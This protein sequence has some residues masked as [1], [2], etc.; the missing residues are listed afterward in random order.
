MD[1]LTAV[2]NASRCGVVSVCR[3][4]V[5]VLLITDIHRS[6]GAAWLAPLVN[7]AD[8]LPTTAS[9]TSINGKK[10]P[11][12]AAYNIKHIHMKLVMTSIAL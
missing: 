8:C 4:S 7:T 1:R 11:D 6:A 5:R 12:D 2:T 10:E 3:S 9:F